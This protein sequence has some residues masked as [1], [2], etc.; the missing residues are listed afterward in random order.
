MIRLKMEKNRKK[1]ERYGENGKIVQNWEKPKA[2]MERQEPKIDM[3][4]EEKKMK[5]SLQAK[6]RPLFFFTKSL[7]KK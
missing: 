7:G 6:L 2:K 4:S 5:I 3:P 1:G